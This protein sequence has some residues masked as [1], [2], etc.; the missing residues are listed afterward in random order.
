MSKMCKFIIQIFRFINF[1]HL[2]PIKKDAN[3][4]V[5]LW[6]SGG[7]GFSSLVGLVNEIGP[8]I[9]AKGNFSKLNEYSW[10]TNAHLL[11]IETP[12]GVGF[13]TS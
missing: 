10:N 8:Y 5:I 11:F 3:S 7:P 6:L 4:P 2:E 9:M 12:L 13:S 1:I